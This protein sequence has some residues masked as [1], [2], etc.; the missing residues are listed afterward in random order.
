[1]KRSKLARLTEHPALMPAVTPGA[2]KPPYQEALPVTT[3]EE[4]TA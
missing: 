1:M 4:A 2:I 3:V